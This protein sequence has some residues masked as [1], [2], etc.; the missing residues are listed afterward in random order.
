[1]N[2]IIATVFIVSF[3]LFNSC[4]NENASFHI[5]TDVNQEHWSYQAE[6]AP[7]HWHEILKNPDCDGMQQSPI[8]IIENNTINNQNEMNEL[9]FLFSPK[10][11]ISLVK[12]NGHTIEFDF[13]PGDSIRYNNV[14][15]HLKQIHF[16]EPSEHTINGIRYPIE[17]HLVH[18]NNQ[19]DFTVVST[20]RR[21]CNKPTV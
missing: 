15:Y 3:V 10:T 7:E 8:N 17:I 9:G 11:Y 18:M 1:M 2:R 12:K 14:T 4:K 20:E 16:H 5:D 21:R 19:N 6:T 13:N